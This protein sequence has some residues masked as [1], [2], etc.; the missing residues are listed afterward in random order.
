MSIQTFNKRVTGVC[1]CPSHKS[2]VAYC[3][4]TYSLSTCTHLRT[5]D[6]SGTGMPSRKHCASSRT[7]AGS[8][9]DASAST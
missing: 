7:H 5:L 2:S 4:H 1:Q 9:A 6:G 3:A 8:T